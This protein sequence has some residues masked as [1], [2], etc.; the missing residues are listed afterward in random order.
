LRV[1]TVISIWEATKTRAFNRHLAAVKANL[2]FRLAPAMRPS[3]LA[4]C[5]ARV[6]GRTP[7][8]RRFPSASASIP[9]A[10]QKFSKLAVIFAGA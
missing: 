6:A 8:A 7:F 4:A 2:A 9:E 3:L 5:R 10:R 1:E